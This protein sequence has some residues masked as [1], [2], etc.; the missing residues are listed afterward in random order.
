MKPEGI[1]T[2]TKAH[3]WILSWGSWIQFTPSLLFSI[4]SNII[5]SFGKNTED[6]YDGNKYIL[7]TVNHLPVD[8]KN[9]KM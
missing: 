4:K 5:P 2:F 8:V 7:I 3:Q 6:K 1:N 9:I